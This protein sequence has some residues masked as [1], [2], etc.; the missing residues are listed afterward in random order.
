LVSQE[1][2]KRTVKIAKVDRS[3]VEQVNIFMTGPSGGEFGLAS[4]EAIVMGEAQ[5]TIENGRLMI[6]NAGESV[7]STMRAGE[8]GRMDIGP[9]SVGQ[10]ALSGEPVI[11]DGVA[12]RFRRR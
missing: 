4:G 5:M 10:Y 7:I 8:P 1:H 9:G 12:F 2:A 3:G 11:V 6:A